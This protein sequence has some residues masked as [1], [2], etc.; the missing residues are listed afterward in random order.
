M[1]KHQFTGGVPTAFVF[2]AVFASSCGGNQQKATVQQLP[3]GGTTGG[4]DDGGSGSGAAGG[5]DGGTGSVTVSDGGSPS[6]GSGS[7]DGGTPASPDALLPLWEYHTTTCMQFDGLADAAGNLY[8][9]ECGDTVNGVGRNWELVSV[10]PTGQQRFRIAVGLLRGAPIVLGERLLLVESVLSSSACEQSLLIALS[11]ADGSVLW[12]HD[13]IPDIT[14]VQSFPNECPEALTGTPSAGPGDG[15]VIVAAKDYKPYDFAAFHDA[16]ILTFDAATGGLL[17]AVKREADGAGSPDLTLDEGGNVYSSDTITGTV[18]S[19][20]PSGNPRWSRPADAVDFPAASTGGLLLESARLPPELTSDILRIRDASDGHVL[21]DVLHGGQPLAGPEGV[22]Y[23]T[24]RD[25]AQYQ[26]KWALVRVDPATGA[27]R[28]V[29]FLDPS[30]ESLPVGSRQDELGLTEAIR[31]S[32]ETYAIATQHSS[33]NVNYHDPQTIYDAPV[34]RE[35]DV[36]GTEVFSATLAGA[37]AIG[38]PAALVNGQFTLAGRDPATQEWWVRSYPFPGR[39]AA[40]TG[41]SSTRANMQRDQ[42]AR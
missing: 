23:L 33:S 37:G 3:D 16:S 7:G 2:L 28:W 31:T 40:T 34:L 36:A 17:S 15:T 4:S 18:F 41:W 39:T 5:T 11:T 8:W 26:T 30:S 32:A 14:A 38:G 20:S 19:L 27:D 22:T 29:R 25:V 13:V 35:I 10:S 21:T 24:V 1:R 12:S 42:R 9:E 6:T